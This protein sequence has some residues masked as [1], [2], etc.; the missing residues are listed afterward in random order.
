MN[1]STA[2]ASVA[3]AALL[4][5]AS[6]ATV[7]RDESPGP[8]PGPVGAAGMQGSLPSA[9]AGGMGAAGNGGDGAAAGKC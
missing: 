7:D 3:L 8:T 5:C 1:R 9:D 6:D 4:G 2:F